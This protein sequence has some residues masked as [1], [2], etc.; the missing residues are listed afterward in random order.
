M[1]VFS[2][3]VQLRKGKP[4]QSK[5]A[6]APKAAKATYETTGNVINRQ[7]GGDHVPL[8]QSRRDNR[9]IRWAHNATIHYTTPWVFKSPFDQTMGL[10]ETT[11]NANLALGFIH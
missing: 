6:T 9:S 2:L 1:F 8:V 4:H 10:P 11:Q 5:A 7:P 3:H